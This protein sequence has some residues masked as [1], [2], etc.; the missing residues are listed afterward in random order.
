[1]HSVKAFRGTK[2]SSIY[3]EYVLPDEVFDRILDAAGRPGLSGELGKDEARRLA[4][5]LTNLRSSGALLDLDDHVTAIAEL[6]RWCGRAS[7]DAWLRIGPRT[8]V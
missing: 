7:D 6:A 2:R 3:R 5:E 8:G 4:E 1:M